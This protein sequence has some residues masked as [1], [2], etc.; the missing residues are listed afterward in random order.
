[1]EGGETARNGTIGPL[2]WACRCMCLLLLCCA[3]RLCQGPQRGPRRGAGCRS[4]CAGWGAGALALSLVVACAVCP[5]GAASSALLLPALP[6]RR[7]MS[8]APHRGSSRHRFPLAYRGAPCGHSAERAPHRGA[9]ADPEGARR[10]PARNGAPGPRGGSH[11]AAIS[12]STCPVEQSGAPAPAGRASR[13]R[14]G[15]G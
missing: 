14:A 1:M 13:T 2:C 3:P 15:R 5:S 7:T 12:G 10:R 9:D 6:A 4:R 8:G 11:R